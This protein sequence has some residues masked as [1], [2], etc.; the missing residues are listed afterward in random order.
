MKKSVRKDFLRSCVMR[1]ILVLMDDTL[2]A[3]LICLKG[4]GHVCGVTYPRIDLPEHQAKRVERQLAE[5]KRW[6]DAALL[7]SGID[8]RKGYH[9]TTRERDLLNAKIGRINRWSIEQKLEQWREIIIT[10][11]TLNLALFWAR[12]EL[13][14]TAHRRM[15]YIEVDKLCL[16]LGDGSDWM[17][18]ADLFDFCRNS[19]L[20]GLPASDMRTEEEFFFRF[21]AMPMPRTATERA[22]FEETGRAADTAALLAI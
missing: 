6:L 19:L 22:I 17:L 21:L 20:D 15:V 13:G 5:C 2:R 10:L 7:Q 4:G 12:L 9:L 16:L 1:H 14:D 18:S 3:I 8:R 11:A